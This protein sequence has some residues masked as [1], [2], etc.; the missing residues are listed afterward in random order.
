MLKSILKKIIPVK[1]LRDAF[2]VFNKIKIKTLDKWFFPEQ[3]IPKEKFYIHEETNP[4]LDS[5]VQTGGFSKKIQE[6]LA[7]WKDHNWTQDQYLLHYKEPAYIEPR[8]GW[9]TTSQQKL[10][11]ASLGFSRAPYVRKPDLTSRFFRSKVVYLER[12][13]S[14]RD[15]GEENY[16]H[17]YN[18]ILPKLFFIEDHNYV[19]KDFTIVVSE[20]LFSREYFQF[21]FKNSSLKDL[22]WHSQTNEWIHFKE[23]IFCKPYTHTK[24]Y[25]ERTIDLAAVSSPDSKNRKLFLTRSKN[26][27]R[28]IEN[29]DEIKTLLEIYQFEII[30]TAGMKVAEQITLFTECRY[31]VSIHGA[32]LT[33]II[34]RRGN[35]LTILEIVQPSDYI[36]FHYILLAH[37]FGYSY[38]VMLGEKGLLHYRGG[39]KVDPIQLKEQLEVMVKSTKE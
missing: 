21:Y 5:R 35:P 26:S 34:F 33:N 15:T 24:K 30:D 3:F 18:D 29:M 39:F 13:I 1:L 17:F 37:Q 8:Y 9:A 10:I 31:L 20:K 22:H 6:K 36:P 38:N 4:F 23:G 2:L 28:F 16:F 27:L 7:L 19:L 25:F 11:Y 32:G 14:L 12:I